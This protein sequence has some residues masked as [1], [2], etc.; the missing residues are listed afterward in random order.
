MND[1]HSSPGSHRK[2]HGGGPWDPRYAGFFDCFNRGRYFEA[3]EVLEGL[4]LTKRQ[5]PDGRFYQGLI[6]LA[7]AFLHLQKQRPGPAAA[8]FRRAHDHLGSYPA[9]HQGLAVREVLGR[10]ALWL[11]QVEGVV[12]GGVPGTRPR[13]EL[14]D[15]G[16]AA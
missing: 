15:P 2:P 13:L 16:P 7:G 14:A 8:L 5:H 9:T 12:G 6:Q 4:W 11:G 10:I 1:R 3:H